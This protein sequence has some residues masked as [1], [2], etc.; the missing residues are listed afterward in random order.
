MQTTNYI[1]RNFKKLTDMKKLIITTVLI[2]LLLSCHENHSLQKETY[3]HDTID[4]KKSIINQEKI[5]FS[6]YVESINYYP[7]PTDH[8]YLIGK[9]G[10]L[11]V[12]DSLFILMDNQIT[13]SVF[14][15]DKKGSRKSC[16]HQHGNGPTEYINL[17]DVYYNPNHQELGLYCN[18]KNRILYY[19]INTGAYL[20]EQKFPYKS[21]MIQLIGENVVQ[22]TEYNENPDLGINGLYPNLIYFTQK[23][24][25]M[26]IGKNYFKGPINRALVT[27]SRGWF[28]L[29]NDT[30]SIK[31]DHCN[32]VYH[33]TK[34]SIFPAHF[35]DFGEYN[36]DER[37]WNKVMEKNINAKKLNDYCQSENLCETIWYMESKNLIHFTCK[38]RGDLSRVI[39]SKKNKKG[40]R[41]KIFEND[42]D[43]IATFQPKTI[44]GNKLYGLLSSHN[45][46]IFCNSVKQDLVPP[47]LKDIKEGDNPVIVEITLK[48]F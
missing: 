38:Q 22:H 25:K 32:I 47:I 26:V 39:Y 45:T 48:D 40:I 27:S 35:L 13:H 16:I 17:S 19:D 3:A 1:N 12:A 33:C 21:D 30:L 8:D 31:P 5:L 46:V 37:Y 28:S 20:R 4:I 7:V 11:I 34:D 29:W 43:M 18:I 41:F 23:N 42:M 9:V 2:P 44:S 6:Q 36:I 15:F 24:P 10:K 14:I